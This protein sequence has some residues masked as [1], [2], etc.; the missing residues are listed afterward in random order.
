MSARRERDLL[1]SLLLLQ[2]VLDCTGVTETSYTRIVGTTKWLACFGT[3]MVTHFR[4]WKLAV[5]RGWRV[6]LQSTKCA[7]GLCVDRASNINACSR[8]KTL[9]VGSA[10]APEHMLELGQDR[11]DRLTTVSE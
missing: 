11:Q 6:S 10:W 5:V 3:K 7:A 1:L 9:E 4:G 2:G 8:L